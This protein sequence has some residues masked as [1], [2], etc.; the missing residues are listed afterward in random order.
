[1][2]C[3]LL[4]RLHFFQIQPDFLIIKYFPC[5]NLSTFYHI[6][7]LQLFLDTPEK[8]RTRD[9]KVR[10]GMACRRKDVEEAIAAFR[11]LSPTI[12]KLVEAQETAL[13]QSDAMELTV[14]NFDETMASYKRKNIASAPKRSKRY[15]TMN[16]EKYEKERIAKY[17]DIGGE[18][19]E[20]NMVLFFG[21]VTQYVEEEKWWHVEYDDGDNEDMSANELM[22]HLE[23]YEANK[24]SDTNNKQH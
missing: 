15:A 24:T 11:K 19:G 5:N 17:F 23:L 20:T 10:I 12:R 18:N 6:A 7:A 8:S 14:E 3:N 2:V 21:T 9:D 13:E 1:M 4:F 16:P 22:T